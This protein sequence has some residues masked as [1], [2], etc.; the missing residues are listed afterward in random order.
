MKFWSASARYRVTV[1]GR[2][3]HY[4][5]HGQHRQKVLGLHA[6]FENHEFDTEVAQKQ[7]R[8]SDDER[9]AVEQ[10]LREHQTFGTKYLRELVPD[11]FAGIEQAAIDAVP[12]CLFRV[13]IDGEV[14]DCGRPALAGSDHCARHAALADDAP[15]RKPSRA[16][17]PA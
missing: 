17:A 11:D 9:E 12:T 6:Q 5:F 15:M 16:A 1:P 14:E 2:E 4:E 3:D 8:W 13:T 10:A 7:L